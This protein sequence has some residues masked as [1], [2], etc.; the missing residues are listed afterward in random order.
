M[1][2]IEKYLYKKENPPLDTVTNKTNVMVNISLLSLDF[3]E[4]KQNF[5][6]DISIQLQW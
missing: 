4:K 2:E 5:K 6:A 1:I 3:N